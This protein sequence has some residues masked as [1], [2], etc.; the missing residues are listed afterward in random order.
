MRHQRTQ[1][2]AIVRL[3]SRDRGSHPTEVESTLLA[4]E[5]SRDLLLQFGHPDVPLYLVVGELD[6]E[7]IHE[8]HVLLLEFLV[9]VE[10]ILR[11]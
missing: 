10:E 1:D 5:P 8:E 9:L 3:P 11:L 2:W 4:S 6:G 7:V